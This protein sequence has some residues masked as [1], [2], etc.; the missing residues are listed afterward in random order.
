MCIRDSLRTGAAQHDLDRRVAAQGLGPGPVQQRPRGVWRRCAGGRGGLE[1]GVVEHVREERGEGVLAQGGGAG[2]VVRSPAGPPVWF[3]SGAAV[4]AR[5]GEPGRG[6]RGP[7]GQ[8]A[9]EVGDQVGPVPADDPAGQYVR[10]PLDG[11]LHRAVRHGGR[12][13]DLGAPAESERYGG[14]AARGP[15]VRVAGEPGVG[16]RQGH[17]HVPAQQPGVERR[18]VA[19]RVF[20]AQQAVE[21]QAVRVRRG[22]RGEQ[23]RLTARDPVRAAGV[24]HGLGA[25][26]R[27]PCPLESVRR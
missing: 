1:V 23:P 17:V 2:A 26:D 5:V 25:V 6:R 12:R 8:P 16:E 7:G 10:G 18:V 14:P 22:P 11:R 27:H 24:G 4:H 9:A 20:G 21:A 3:A 19:E 15:V 13:A